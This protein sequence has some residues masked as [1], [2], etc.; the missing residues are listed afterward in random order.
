MDLCLR[1]GETLMANGAGAADVTA[2]MQSLAIHL[3]LRAAEIDVTFTSLTM[4]FQA[5]ADAPP[6]I[7]TRH[8]RHRDIDY[9]DLTRADHLVRDLL[10]AR[11][12]RDEA[13]VRPRGSLR[14]A[15]GCRGRRSPSGPA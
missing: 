4:S 8:V 15:T 11:L 13:R 7:Q 5:A 14:P 2:T 1:V 10:A 9:E 12:T 6:F 3:G